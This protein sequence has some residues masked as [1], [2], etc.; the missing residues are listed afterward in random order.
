MLNDDL[1]MV[2]FNLRHS[3]T[4][5]YAAATEFFNR[6]NAERLPDDPPHTL[7]ENIA[8]WQSIP[9][10][11][12]IE[13]WGVWR[14]ADQ[15]VVAAGSVDYLQTGQ[16]E[17]AVQFAVEVLPEY[18]RQGLG[19]QLL[20]Q[21]VAVAQRKQRTLMITN[22]D[23]RIPA[24]ALCVER[25]GAR[26]GIENHTNQLRMDELNRALVAKWLAAGQANAG[27]FELGFWDGAYPEADLPQV[28]RMSDL[29]NTMPRDALELEDIHFTAEH[30]RQMEQSRKARGI[31]F[32]TTFVR[33]RASGNIVGFSDVYWHPAR[34]A[35]LSQ[36][37]TGVFPEYRNRGIGR[38]LKAAML[39]KVLREKPQVQFVRT[40]NADSNAP[41]L[42]INVELGFKPYMSQ[43]VWQVETEKAARYLAERAARPGAG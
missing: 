15:A 21:I 12:Q 7:A 19:T 38:W 13:A 10:F 8:G 18:R 36:G 22:T 20:R 1:T 23:E 34:P 27:A 6:M 16:N 42:K 33:E 39:D 9:D 4:A 43:T 3:D 5:T 35:I 14:K 25:L 24:G 32:W 31:T 41:M 37:N 30:V 2:P 29:M 11:V 40:S 26:K 17:H 28:L